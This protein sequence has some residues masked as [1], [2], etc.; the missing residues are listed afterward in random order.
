MF[1]PVSNDVYHHINEL[2]EEI[3]KIELQCE[4][5]KAQIQNEK[6]ALHVCN[7]FFFIFNKVN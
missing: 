3:Q 7:S 1:Y 6:P 5:Y 2:N 4:E